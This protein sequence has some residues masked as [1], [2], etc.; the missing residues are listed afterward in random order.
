MKKKGFIQHHFWLKSGAGLTLIEILVVLFIMGFIATALYYVLNAGIE[1]WRAGKERTDIIAQARVAMD[2]LTREAREATYMVAADSTGI[3][4][5]AYLGETS[6][7]V[8]SYYYDS[9]EDI[10]YRYNVTDGILSEMAKYMDSFSLYYY[11]KGD[12]DAI[13][14]FTPT[15]GEY[16]SIWMI[17][18]ETKLKRGATGEENIVH[19]RSTVQP[20]NYPYD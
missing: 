16:N 8:I 5:S 20:R 9:S 10:L 18:I 13:H 2:R 15:T 17:E 3:N 11:S 14:S 4:F 19:L 7:K 6:P 12:D 1:G